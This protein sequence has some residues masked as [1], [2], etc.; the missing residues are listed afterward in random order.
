MLQGVRGANKVS[1]NQRAAIL[2]ATEELLSALLEANPTMRS[3]D[4]ASV[5]LTLTPD[6][7]AA[8]PAEAARRLGWDQVALLCM[9][10]LPV[11]GA[12]ASVVRVLLHWNTSNPQ[13]AVRHVYL[14]ETAA[15]RPDL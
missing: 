1:A 4:L 7:D 11:P 9:Q 10:E 2:S 6:L 8:F 13:A 5:I 12:M 15:L 3:A 14:G